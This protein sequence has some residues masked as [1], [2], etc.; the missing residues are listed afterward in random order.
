MFNVNAHAP[1]IRVGNATV[2]PKEFEASCELPFGGIPPGLFGNILPSF[3]HNLFGI[4]IM[5]D[6]DCKVLFIKGSVIIYEKN[7]NPFLTGWRETDGAKLWRI[8]LQIDLANFQPCPN[9]PDN[10]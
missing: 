9:D 3:W 8:S 6:K 10:I 7:K 2:H 5:C 4:E 1:N